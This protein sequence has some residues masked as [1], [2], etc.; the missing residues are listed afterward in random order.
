MTGPGTQVNIRPAADRKQNHGMFFPARNQ[1]TISKILLQIYCLAGQLPLFLLKGT[2]KPV[3]LIYAEH[4]TKG[5]NMQIRTTKNSTHIFS[6]LLPVLFVTLL[7]TGCSTIEGVLN[8]TRPNASIERV[9]LSGL[10]FDRVDLVFYVEVHNPNS[11][12]LKLAGLEYNLAME[13]NSVV[14]GNVEKGIELPARGSSLLEVPVSV[15]YSNI[16]NTVQSAREKDNL[17][18]QIDLG[19]SFTVPGYSSL[20]VPLTYAGTIPV[21][22][23][24][25]LSMA[26]LQVRNISL[27]RID[28]E[29]RLEVNNP[30]SFKIDMNKFNYDLT[31]AGHS[32]VRGNTVRPL[33]FREKSRSVVTIPLSLNIV[34]VGRSVID[35]LS[36][37]R[38]LDY[39]FSGDTV[40]DTELPL[41]QDYL[42]SFSSEGET[43]IFR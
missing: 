4:K 13:K 24:P 29:L 8:L 3:V 2:R 23:L 27:T 39:Q 6:I 32:W 25:S 10:S 22:K 38:T 14:R 37:N 40:M 36:G 19:L 26:S 41:L 35:L 11:I 33:S 20:K 30:N 34:E 12:G 1:G 21:P 9:E 15:G 16:F 17:D 43:E 18:Y 5:A 42:F 28:V 7:F 31:I